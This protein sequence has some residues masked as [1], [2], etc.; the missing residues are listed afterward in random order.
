MLTFSEMK[1]L[2]RTQGSS[3]KKHAEPPSSVSKAPAIA[4]SEKRAVQVNESSAAIQGQLMANN[5]LIS[6]TSKRDDTLGQTL[7]K[8]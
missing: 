4:G 5:A 8:G 6:P 3:D 2:V 7:S 1:G